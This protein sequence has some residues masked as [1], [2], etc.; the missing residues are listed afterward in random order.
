MPM[1]RITGPDGLP[2]L[3][4]TQ[5]DDEQSDNW[6][7]PGLTPAM[8]DSSSLLPFSGMPRSNEKLD[9]LMRYF[10]IAMNRATDRATPSEDN[11]QFIDHLVPKFPSDMPDLAPSEL[12]PYLRRGWSR[13]DN[14]NAELLPAIVNRDAPGED[15]L[16]PSELL[17]YLRRNWPR[18]DSRNAEQLL[19]A[20]I[21]RDAPEAD[22]TQIHDRAFFSRL[23]QMQGLTPLELD[24]AIYRK[25]SPESAGKYIRLLPGTV[26]GDEDPFAGLQFSRRPNPDYEQKLVAIEGG[27]NGMQAAT[28]AKGL[29]LRA[30]AANDDIGPDGNL[31]GQITG[32]SQRDDEYKSP[33]SGKLDAI[34]NQMGLLNKFSFP[35]SSAVKSVPASFIRQSELYARAPSSLPLFDEDADFNPSRFLH[36]THQPHDMR[37]EN[38][39]DGRAISVDAENQGQGRAWDEGLALYDNIIPIIKSNSEQDERQS[40]HV[41]KLQ[42]GVPLKNYS[43]MQISDTPFSE[44]QLLDHSDDS[45]SNEFLEAIPGYYNK[46]SQKNEKAQDPLLASNEPVSLLQWNSS[47]QSENKGTIQKYAEIIKKINKVGNKAMREKW[48]EAELS[49]TLNPN[50]LKPFPL[51][52][53]PGTSDAPITFNGNEA[54]IPEF[55][56]GLQIPAIKRGQGSGVW[57]EKPREFSAS[58]KKFAAQVELPFMGIVLPDA[59]RHLQHYFDNTGKDYQVDLKRIVETTDAGRDLY[60]SQRNGA[61]K[62]AMEHAKEGEPLNFSSRRLEQRVFAEGTENWFYASGNFSGYSQ[63]KVIKNGDSFSMNFELNYID[64]YDWD[65]KSTQL[66]GAGK[67]LDKDMAEFH[68]QGIAKDF[69][70]TG[71]LP[72]IITWKAGN[73]M[74]PVVKIDHSKMPKPDHSQK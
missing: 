35:Q 8:E 64:P 47:P 56:D 15:D 33:D 46:L 17:P 68:K 16:A 3:I 32:Q 24:P 6:A 2:Y 9:N 55:V 61:I 38:G 44:D 18:T 54:P 36:D 5:E 62:Y 40:P 45:D 57:G 73:E 26:S 48:N 58:A 27:G 31:T 22:D 21:N 29:L 28:P 72:L 69:L 4:N 12:L 19:P 66:F 30:M 49:R 67:V 14:R 34:D 59:S 25:P 41:Q 37:L 65:R 20:I 63:S 51:Q 10:P 71:K 43:P 39:L 60:L 70:L 53:Q 52:P 42:G 11:E 50:E 1:K 13:T 74:N 7:S 23:H